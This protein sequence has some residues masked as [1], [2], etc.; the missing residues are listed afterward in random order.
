MKLLGV[1]VSVVLL[2]ADNINLTSDP[3]SPTKAGIPFSMSGDGVEDVK[4]PSVFMKKLDANI[5]HSL[6]LETGEVEVELMAAEEQHWDQSTGGDMAGNSNEEDKKEMERKEDHEKE[7][8]GDEQQS[9]EVKILSKKVQSLLEGINTDVLPDELRESVSRELD[10]LKE[11]NLDPNGGSGSC[12]AVSKD[13]LKQTVLDQL[14]T[15][16]ELQSGKPLRIAQ[17]TQPGGKQSEMTS[18]SEE[19]TIQGIS[20]ERT[21]LKP[22]EDKG[23]EPECAGSGVGGSNHDTCTVASQSASDPGPG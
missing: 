3:A 14:N 13:D 5:L 7:L 19:R 18:S 8:E 12:A 1:T 20:E 2:C 23:D 4:I 16:Q 21:V 17:D 9:D 10:K 15:L 22:C 11:L 6:L